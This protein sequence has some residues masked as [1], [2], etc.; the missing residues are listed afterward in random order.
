MACFRFLTYTAVV[1]SWLRNSSQCSLKAGIEGN[2]RLAP[3]SSKAWSGRGPV[4][5]ATVKI[6]AATPAR[7]PRGAFSITIASLGLD[8]GFLKSHQ[9]R[10]RI[11]FAIFHIES[12]Y[13]KFAFENVWKMWF[14]RSRNDYCP[15]PVTT[16]GIKPAC[17]I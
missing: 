4:F 16:I 2:N 8:A 11:R 17:L 7:T 5:T 14:E 9:I 13:H 1:F 3:S 10:F 15:E 6:P 12:S